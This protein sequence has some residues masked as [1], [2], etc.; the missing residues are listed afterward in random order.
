MKLVILSEETDRS[1][2]IVC[3]WL[4]WGHTPYIRINS[5]KFV[6]PQIEIRGTFDD[7][8]VI[9]SKNGFEVNL[10]ETETVWFRRP[11]PNT[12]ITSLHFGIHYIP[13]HIRHLL[14]TLPHQIIASKKFQVGN[15]LFHQWGVNIDIPQIIRSFA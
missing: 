5:E 9:L 7:S 14:I 11:F 12:L 13:N 15:A 4:Q 1:S 3:Y 6:N 2:D 8:S 10:S